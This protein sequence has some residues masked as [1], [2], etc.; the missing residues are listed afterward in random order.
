MAM[1]TQLDPEGGYVDTGGVLIATPGVSGQAE[2]VHPSPDDSR[3]DAHVSEVMAAALAE[4]DLRV[5][6]DVELSDLSVGELGES[7]RGSG[8]SEPVIVA[9][10]PTPGDGLAQVVLLVDEDGLLTWHR[11]TS[12][13]PAGP[14]GT[15]G[16]DLVTYRIPLRSP[17]DTGDAR[18]PV[19]WLSKK[20]LKVLVFRL[21]DE[22]LARAGRYLAGR[23]EEKHRWYGLRTVTGSSGLAGEPVDWPAMT[24][25]PALLLVHG[26]FSRGATAFSGLPAEQLRRLSDAYSGRV[27]IFD[28]PTV[29]VDPVTN[30]RWFVEQFTANVPVGAELV[31]DVIAHSRGGLVARALAEQQDLLALDG[32]IL[33]VRSAVFVGSPNAGTVL[34]DAEHLGDLL[35][36]YTNML[37]AFPDI[38]AVDVLQVVLEVVK[39]VATGIAEGLDGLMSMNPGGEYLRTL[40]K[41]PAERAGYAAIAADFSPASRDPRQ[42]AMNLVADRL[43]RGANDLVVPRDGAWEVDD[44]SLVAADQRLSIADEDAV[45]HNSY[46][47]NPAVQERLFE[48]LGG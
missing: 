43:F 19:G 8:E 24:A 30:A 7:G 36:S 46:F 6:V 35:D 37:D 45:T 25:G 34:A 17:A 13:Q 10:V 11:P 16:D 22:A 39:Q 40:N 33:D 26:T 42:L 31:I 20:V 48:L 14:G 3:A 12:G 21:L 2:A 9:Q 29:S 41:E 28:H 1:A 27:T 44:C 38:G 23:W 4:A 47:N 5:Q 32:R 18:G 15:R